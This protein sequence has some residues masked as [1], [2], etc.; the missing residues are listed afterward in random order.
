MNNYIIYYV[1]RAINPSLFVCAGFSM[2]VNYGVALLF[3]LSAFSAYM[4][5]GYLLEKTMRNS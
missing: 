5:E 4:L 3:L 1:C 2:W